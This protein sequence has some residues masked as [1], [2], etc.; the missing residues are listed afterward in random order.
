MVAKRRAELISE[1]DRKRRGDSAFRDDDDFSDDEPD[2][3][4]DIENILEEEFPKDE[5]E[6]SEEDEEQE[7]E[8]V[9]RLRSEMGEKFETEMN[10]LQMIQEEFEKVLV[11]II[12]VNGAR[13]LNI[14]QYV[15]NSKLKPLVE[16]RASI[17]EKCYPVSPHL[18]H[19]MLTFT[20]KYI[21]SFGYWD[22]VKL[23][24][25]ETIKPVENAENPLNPVIHRQYIYFL[26]SKQTKE[27]FMMNPIKY[28]RQPKPKA[29][30]PVRIMIVGPP[31]SGKTTVA[32][33]L[34]SEY[35]LKRLSVGA[36]LRS[37]LSNH[38]DT[39]LSLMI[40]WHLH[41]GMTVPDALAIQALDLSLMESVC[42]T[43]GVVID[44]YPVT[45]NQMNILETRS[46]IPMVIFELDVPSKEIFKRLLFERKMEQSTPYPLHN[47]TQIIAYKN[48]KYR[49]NVSEIRQ[50]YREQH[51]N[52]HVIDGFHRKAAC[53]DKLCITPE[54][55]ISRLGEFGQFCPVSLAESYELVDCSV[56]NSLEFAAE[57]RGHYYKMGSQEKLNKFLMNP[58]LYVPPLAPHP[59]PPAAMLPKR[60][61]LSELKS[62]FPKCAEL[63]GYCPVTYLDGKQRQALI[64]AGQTHT[65]ARYDALVPGNI[66]YAVEYRDRI[67]ICESEEK[68]Q[69]FLRLPMRY[70]DQKLPHKLPPLKESI[71]LT[72]LPLP[73]YLE[74]GTATSLIKA[75]NAAGCLKPK[76]PFL[77]VRRSV[78]LYV[79]FHLKG[80]EYSRK[81][82]KKKMEKFLERCELI[83]YLSA[84]MTRKYKEPQFRAI[85]FDHKLQTF[86][87]LRNIDPVTG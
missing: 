50:F 30:M 15:L 25:G 6:M 35:G 2:E 62:R 61:T 14:V 49:K 10:N 42:N 13:K 33:K 4:E 53:I 79:G 84:K 9:E 40:N 66:Q 29:S 38:P 5:E 68:L 20:Y 58:E 73:G 8:A 76:F 69:K 39:E 37:M 24:E 27:K 46:I 31:K 87:A 7:G 85:D 18:A 47:S 67:F 64:F 36:A 78:L 72:S 43:I 54:E 86:L 1:R 44:G 41:K 17:F 81:K 63:Q 19:K 28:I 75:L 59:L 3:E 26:S 16:N 22:P 71:H 60:L 34:A 23:S 56:T 74:Q 52:W 32:K 65:P 51:Q 82:Y 77:S 48:A 11:P 83:T 12:T 21:S 80:S 45:T 70:W 57:F 55:L